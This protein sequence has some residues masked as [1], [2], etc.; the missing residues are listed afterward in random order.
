MSFAALK[1]AAGALMLVSA[2][3]ASGQQAS[4]PAPPADHAADRIYD[5]KAMADARAR[6]HQE[7]GGQTFSAIMV[8]LAE[9]QFLK[10]HD[11]YRWE[12]EAWYG[13]DINR[14]VL[15]TEGEGAFGGSTEQAELQALYSR[16]IGPYFNLQAGLR[17]DFRPEPSR[18]YATLGV[19]GLAPYMIETTATV[20]LSD[21]GD[22]LARVEAYYDQLVT[23]TL[24][25]Q[26][27]VEMNFAAQD[28]PANGI[29]AGV[30]DI[31]LGLRLRYEI[32]RAFAPYVGVS[33]LRKTAK[34][35]NY[36]RRAGEPVGGTAFVVGIRTWF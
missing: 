16:A 28:V 29:G 21:K 3:A 11:S 22:A 10:G 12:A 4:E 30:T 25:L 27:R 24:V 1:I 7:H 35:A 14:V 2:T 36:A 31:E 6:L 20:F 23:Q 19:E 33:Y 17:Y 5:P 18:A 32:T 9:Y 15:K 13:G 34:T 26:P 8:N